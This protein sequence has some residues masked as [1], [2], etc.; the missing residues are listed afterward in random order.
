MKVLQTLQTGPNIK[1]REPEKKK[2][3]RSGGAT[4]SKLKSALS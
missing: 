3:L 2:Q 1:G 4:T